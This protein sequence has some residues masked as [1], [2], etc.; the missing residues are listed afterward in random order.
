MFY[1]LKSFLGG[2]GYSKGKLYNLH[3]NIRGPTWIYIQVILFHPN[4]ICKRCLDGES[5]QYLSKITSTWK[6][7]YMA[8]TQVLGINRDI[9]PRY[10]YPSL[11][12]ELN[13]IMLLHFLRFFYMNIQKASYTSYIQI[14]EDQPR[15][16]SKWSFFSRVYL[17]K[18]LM[19]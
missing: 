18:D 3:P 17:R 19:F 11:E 4:F 5:N 12:D 1:V 8:S 15:H 6:A 7:S 13:M 10:H 16:T 2:D 9:R 14:F